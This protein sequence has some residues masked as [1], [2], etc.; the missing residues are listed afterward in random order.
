MV[1]PTPRVKLRVRV[2]G[3][4]AIETIVECGTTTD[5]T[6]RECLPHR[7]MSLLGELTIDW[8]RSDVWAQPDPSVATFNVW[9]SDDASAAWPT[10]NLAAATPGS[11]MVGLEFHIDVPKGASYFHIF[12]GRVVNVDA[13]RLTV[14]TTRGLENG[15]IFRI[16]AS[17]K[18]GALAQVDKQGFVKLDAGR[19][20][21]ANADFLNAFASWVSIRET[22]FEAAYQNGKC[23]FVDMTD[24]NLYDVIVELYASFSHQ[25]TYNPMRNVL[26]R[27]PAA[28][29]HGAF[30]LK[31]GRTAV[32]GIVR[33]YA[34]QW[35]DNT[36]REDPQDSDP[37]PSGYIGG[38]DVGG[39]VRLSS[40]QGQAIS[41]IEC[42]WTNGPGGN[43]EIIS[44][45]LVAGSAN[46]GLLRFDS[47]FNDG[48]QIDPIMQDIKRKCL[49]EGARPFHPT[50]S[51]DT[52]K[53]GDVPD[54]NTFQCLTMPA[55]S[56]RMTVV[57]GSP[58]ASW[59]N[60]APV[61]YPA[62]GVIAYSAGKWRF[63]TQL[64]P[65]PMTLTGSPITC[66]NLSGNGTGATL[67]LGQLDQSISSHDLK[68]VSDPA[69]YIWE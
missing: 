45:V 68:Y 5:A 30:S 48:L 28:Y 40:D 3:G 63:D 15:W 9:Q 19:T 13:E 57:A 31:F 22:Y 33:L 35:I 10:L 8:G 12:R 14:R 20:M 43:T 27:I 69:L 23:R 53:A 34:P 11:G 32:G 17:D 2:P 39:D 66:A 47:W 65:A 4:T 38:N 25:F 52:A 44:R 21:K 49:A 18:S 56:V 67:T 50:V 51:W 46:L 26:I 60:V 58:F 64:A 55:Q 29:N 42:K 62:G 16:Q 7:A 37:Y 41:H 59:M 36:G 54:W 24:K 61:W 6:G 1:N